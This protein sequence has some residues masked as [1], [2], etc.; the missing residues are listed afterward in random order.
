MVVLGRGWEAWE[1]WTVFLR[2][3]SRGSEMALVCA[4]RL[5]VLDMSQRQIADK[6]GPG[7]QQLGT[8]FLER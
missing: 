1:S 2:Q 8:H 3:R 4:E 5:G 7:G 6:A